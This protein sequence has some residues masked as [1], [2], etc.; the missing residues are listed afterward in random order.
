V[1]REIRAGVV[2]IIQSQEVEAEGKTRFL[3]VLTL[4]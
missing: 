3:V 2:L 4:L 1:R